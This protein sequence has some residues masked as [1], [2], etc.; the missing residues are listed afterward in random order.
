MTRRSTSPGTGPQDEDLA[1]AVGHADVVERANVA[2]LG[3]TGA[4]KSTLLNTIFGAD[5]ADT[6]VGRPVT[7]GSALY[8]NEAGTLAIYDQEGMELGARRSPAKAVRDRIGRNRSR[9]TD[10]LIHVA[11]YCVNSGTARLEPGQ[12]KAI[13]ELAGA[14]I[15]VV[16][17]LT[18]VSVRE[19][20]VDPAVVAFADA[21]AAMGLPIVGGRPMVTSAVEDAFNHVG[22]HGLIELLDATYRAVPEAQRVALA[23]AQKIDLKI[24]ARY[25]RSWI[26]GATAFAGGVGAVPIPVADAAV[27]VP[28]QAALMARIATVYDIPRAKAA[29]MIGAATGAAAAGG[30]VAAASLLKLVPGVGSVI[31]AGVASTITAVLGESWRVTTERAFVG[32]LDLDD[33]TQ[34]ADLV[35]GFTAQV[36][37]GTGA[38]LAAPDG[39]EA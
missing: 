9:E 27:L 30:K 26:A 25:A 36:K 37:E 32:R 31:S 19:G 2:L 23:A 8:V 1:A 28:A 22:R 15:P 10:A 34:V 21:I 11:W 38:S 6:G 29:Q 13:R 39:P 16:L 5:V 35:T 18:K 7:Q 17:V 3:A 14:G 24:K 33:A 4:G 12:E 20:V